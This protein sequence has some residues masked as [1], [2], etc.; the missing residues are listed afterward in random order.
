MK[1]AFHI[2]YCLPPAFRCEIT[3]ATTMTTLNQVFSVGL[4]NFI[5]ASSVF[6]VER[7]LACYIQPLSKCQ[8]KDNGWGARQRSATNRQVVDSRLDEVNVFFSMYLFL[9]AAVGPGVYLA[10]NRNEYQKQKNNVYRK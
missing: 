4:T 8:S 9:P 10:S 5:G 1:V 7:S 2:Q 3:E 6:C